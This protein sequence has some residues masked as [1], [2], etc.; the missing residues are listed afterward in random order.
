MTSFE[1][2]VRRQHIGEELRILR[3]KAN[4]TL[5]DA[6]KVINASPSKVSRIETGHRSVSPV[7]VSALVAVYKA[8]PRKRDQLLALAEESGE[9]GWWQGNRAQYAK[10]KRTLITLESKAESIVHFDLTLIP[11]LLQTAEYTRAVM[12]ECGYVPQ[13]DIDDGMTTRLRRQSVLVRR[14]PP[15]LLAVIDELALHR[16]VGGRDVLRR[17]LLHLVQESN[18][19]HVELRVVPNDGHAHSGVDGSFILIRRPELSPVV[20]VET[21]TSSLFVEDRSEVKM[22]EAA[23]QRLLTRAQ[24]AEESV[25]LVA[26]LARQLDTEASNGWSRPT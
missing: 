8:D 21:L 5:D 16:L 6:A 20:L 13:E 1:P 10:E 26:S 17:Q 18:R 4:Y 15:K 12:L 2:T 19:Q 22:Y 25:S 14:D 7:E 24:S 23:L 3:K 11:G 9:I